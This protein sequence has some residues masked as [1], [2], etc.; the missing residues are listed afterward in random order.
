MHSKNCSRA[1][2]CGCEV[3]RYAAVLAV[4]LAIA[5]LEL[6][7][8]YLSGSLALMADTFHVI[9][10]GGAIVVAMIL[11]YLEQSDTTSETAKIQKRG[12]YIQAAL[13]AIVALG[14]A[15]EA[16]DRLQNPTPI[17]SAGMLAVAVLGGI[18]NYIQHWMIRK[19]EAADDQNIRRHNLARHILS[20]LIQSI[21]VI[22]GGTL[23]LFTGWLWIDPALSLGVALFIAYQVVQ[24]LRDSRTIMPH[25]HHL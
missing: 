16:L 24:I 15:F 9:M 8:G 18:G 10:D 5:A 21:A 6:A 4:A 13:L 20:D 11:A 2:P 7:G 25:H 12:A 23:I 3:R 22:A 19:T 17:E 1:G 14:V